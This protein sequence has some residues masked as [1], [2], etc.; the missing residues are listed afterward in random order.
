MVEESGDGEEVLIDEETE[1][2]VVLKYYD[3]GASAQLFYPI[4][5]SL[6]DWAYGSGWDPLVPK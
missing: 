1:E 3:L 4:A 2:E 6:V 5:G